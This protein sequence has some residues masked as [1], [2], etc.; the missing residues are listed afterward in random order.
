MADAVVF[1][2]WISPNTIAMV[3]D[4]SVYHWSIEGDSAPKKVF[5][6]H[7]SLRAGNQIINYQVSG[8]GKWSLLIGISAGAGGAIQGNMQLF[9]VDKNVSQALQGHAGIFA[10]V[11]PDPSDARFAG[12]RGCA[13]AGSLAR[14]ADAPTFFC[15]GAWP[16]C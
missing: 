15:H 16:P 3:T 11:K 1:W 4:T 2:R 6:R 12:H 8:D 9:S 10:T 13:R 7:E 5:D 14:H